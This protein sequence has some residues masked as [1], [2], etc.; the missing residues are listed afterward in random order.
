MPTQIRYGILLNKYVWDSVSSDRD[1]LVFTVQGRFGVLIELKYSDNKSKHDI[2][3]SIE[4]GDTLKITYDTDAWRT[5]NSKYSRAIGELYHSWQLETTNRMVYKGDT[6]SCFLS[7]KSWSV[8]SKPAHI[9]GR[10]VSHR[11]HFS[12]SR[13]DFKSYYVTL[14]DQMNTR[15]VCQIWVNEAYESG[16]DE[17]LK[18]AANSHILLLNARPLPR[19]RYFDTPA[20]EFLLVSCYAPVVDRDVGLSSIQRLRMELHSQPNSYYYPYRLL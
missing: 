6:F 10:Y 2:Y 19:E 4:V 11:E 13:G 20:E 17:L 1:L 18:N 15:F 5:P 7:V 3:N 16:V 9:A 8:A 12:A 14:A